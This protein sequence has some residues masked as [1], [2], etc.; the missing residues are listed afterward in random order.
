MFHCLVTLPSTVSDTEQWGYT[1]DRLH[2]SHSAGDSVALSV[3]SLSPK[4][5]GI[6]VPGSM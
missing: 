3:G 5:S 6:W 1:A 2:K 4:P